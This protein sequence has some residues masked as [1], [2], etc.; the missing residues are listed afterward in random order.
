MHHLL[1]ISQIG[2]QINSENAFNRPA[3]TLYD[4]TTFQKP[5]A[6]VKLGPWHWQERLADRTAAVSINSRSE[7]DLEIFI[8][9]LK[10]SEEKLV[11]T[12]G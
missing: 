8:T 11:W 7:C 12:G 10:I 3:K 6:P 2:R 4:P 9:V 1:Q 5:V